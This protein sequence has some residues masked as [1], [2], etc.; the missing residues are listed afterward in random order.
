MRRDGRLAR[1]LHVLVHMDKRGGKTTSETLALMLNTNPVVVRR[2]MGAL[3]QAGLVTSDGGHGGG[4]TL[5]RSLESVTIRDVHEALGAPDVLALDAAADH[6]ACPV[7]RAAVARLASIFGATEAF[8]LRA[9]GEVR[10]SA[11]AAEVD[12]MPPADT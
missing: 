3:K 1:M 6:P 9:M 5:L 11:I 10:L 7:E 2:T 4:W 8:M 12:G